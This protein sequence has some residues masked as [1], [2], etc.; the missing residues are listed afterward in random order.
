M[1]AIEPGRTESLYNKL[2][3]SDRPIWDIWL[4]MNHLPAVA[5]A[6]EL[7]IFGALADAPIS[8]VELANVLSLNERATRVLVT[9]LAALQLVF[10]TDNRIH[11][12]PTAQTYLLP[13]SPY[14]WGPL[15]R[16]LGFVSSLHAALLRA[17]R[18]GSKLTSSVMGELPSTAWEKGELTYER[19]ASIAKIMH[20]HSVPAAISAARWEK[21]SEVSKLLDVGGGSGCFSLAI[22]EHHPK[23]RCTIMELQAAC[24]VAAEYVA[25]ADFTHRVDVVSANMFRDPWPLGYDGVFFSNIFHDWSTDEASLLAR[26][27]WDA[28]PT[29]GLVFVHEMLLSDEANGPVPAASFSILMMLGTKG[30][31]YSFQ[32]VKH[33]LVQAGFAQIERRDTG[34][35]FSVIS[36]RKLMPLAYPSDCDVC[37]PASAA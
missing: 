2:P 15:L 6:D 4:S 3:P 8:V 33:V 23:I 29:G 30:E 12:S 20:C 24:D 11:I 26:R 22:A 18:A 32:Q 9:M 10:L 34:G 5:V 28:L 16:S 35:Y 1:T 13:P 21:F 27:A 31:Q 14:Y 37:L 7:G 19:A 17:L 25:A 36:A